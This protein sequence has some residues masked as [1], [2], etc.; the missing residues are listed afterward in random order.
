M[1]STGSAALDLCF[2][3]AGRFDGYWQ[4]DLAAW[5]IAGGLI[6]VTEAGGFVSDGEG[7]QNMLDTGSVIAG[8]QNMVKLLTGYTVPPAAAKPV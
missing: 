2:T 8:N 6:M 3:A 1:R 5:D 7:R 4:R